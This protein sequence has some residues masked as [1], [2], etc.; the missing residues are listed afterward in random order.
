MSLR[1]MQENVILSDLE[2]NQD[3]EARRSVAD[4][5]HCGRHITRELTWPTVFKDAAATR[6]YV[7]HHTYICIRKA[8]D[9]MLC[10]DT[11]F[12][13]TLCLFYHRTIA[14][15]WQAQHCFWYDIHD[16]SVFYTVIR[17]I[18]APPWTTRF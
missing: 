14:A 2:N 17:R 11:T 8:V 18:P 12:R 16:S 7:A 15:V 13:T 1:K 6:I 4:A 3:L 9:T 10:T 5:E